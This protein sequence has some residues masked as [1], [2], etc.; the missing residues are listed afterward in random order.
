MLLIVGERFNDIRGYLLQRE[1]VRTRVVIIFHEVQEVETLH[2]VPDILVL[3][4]IPK[5][6]EAN[7]PSPKLFEGV[8]LRKVHPYIVARRSFDI[9]HCA[10]SVLS[11]LDES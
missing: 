4:M 10:D 3:L 11:C 8:T 7:N 5:R 2:V 6:F 9:A 1:N